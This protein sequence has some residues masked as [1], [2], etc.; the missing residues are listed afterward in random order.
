MKMRLL[1]Q[2]K[3]IS[4]TSVPKPTLLNVILMHS[5]YG[6]LTDLHRT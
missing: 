1:R 5:L 2:G 4:G 3:I 6:D